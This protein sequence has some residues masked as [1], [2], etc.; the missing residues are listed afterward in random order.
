MLYTINTSKQIFNRT[1]VDSSDAML[2]LYNEGDV[3]I[4]VTILCKKYRSKDVCNTE[5][6]WIN[7]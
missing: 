1:V 3:G 2:R 4:L 7:C 6:R 5:C